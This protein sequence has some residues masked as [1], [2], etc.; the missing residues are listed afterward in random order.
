MKN[1]KNGS[2]LVAA[3]VVIMIIMV[4]LGAALS[5]ASSYYKTSVNDMVKK[6]VYLS[7]KSSIHLVAN[8]IEENNQKLIPENVGDSKK[9]KDIDVDGDTC[10]ETGTVTKIDDNTIKI[11]LESAFDDVTYKMQL[12]MTYADYKW[13]IDSYCEAKD[14]DQLC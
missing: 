9:I 14:G 7:A 4:V 13:S 8:Y 5:I 10:T 11:V 6:Q 3:I 2:T 1:N 12:I